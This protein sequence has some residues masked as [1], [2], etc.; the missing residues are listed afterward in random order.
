MRLNEL[1]NYHKKQ[2]GAIKN[3]QSR[4]VWA[5]SN[6]VLMFLEPSIVKYTSQ[7]VFMDEAQ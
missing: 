3:D 4:F 1:L 2:K 7:P 6:L 5:T